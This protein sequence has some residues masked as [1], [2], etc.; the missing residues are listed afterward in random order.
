MA[1][2]LVKSAVAAGL[3]PVLPQEFAAPF[4][5]TRGVEFRSGDHIAVGC[6]FTVAVGGDGTLLYA[7]QQLPDL[8]M[9][10]VHAGELG[11]LTPV[12]PHEID[13]LVEA[14][15]ADRLEFQDLAVLEVHHGD[16]VLLALNDA[17]IAK[18]DEGRAP[19]LRLWI[20]GVEFVT[21][22]ADA[23]VLATPTGSTGYTFSARGPIVS[24][25]LAALVVTPVAPHTLWDRPLVL[26]PTSRVQVELVSNRAG[27]L[28]VDGTRSASLPAGEA[29]D[30]CVSER[31][32]RL[33]TW[34]EIDAI[35]R[36]RRLTE[37]A[38]DYDV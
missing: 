19:K 25:R 26:G 7:F 12:Q 21:M 6:D 37:P 11:F 1:T 9:V 13:T 14:A 4:K 35:T 18:G 23:I 31:V 22:L 28:L 24:Q 3:Q 33:A 29:V 8:P 2:A 32:A 20:D 36:L 27:V 15:V 17:V 34:G 30:I 5:D 38:R 10:G 16:E